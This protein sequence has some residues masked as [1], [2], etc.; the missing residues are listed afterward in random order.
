[1]DACALLC[2][3]C[4]HHRQRLGKVLCHQGNL[5]CLEEDLTARKLLQPKCSAQQCSCTLCQG[6]SVLVLREEDVHAYI[7]AVS[8]IW[9]VMPAVVWDAVCTGEHSCSNS[10]NLPSSPG[11]AIVLPQACWCLPRLLCCAG[12]QLRDGGGRGP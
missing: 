7:M 9:G 3:I 8:V 2:H 6:E 4:A 5:G 10:Q 12:G 11:T 1:M